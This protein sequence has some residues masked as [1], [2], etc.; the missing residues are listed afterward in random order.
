MNEALEVAQLLLASGHLVGAEV[1][2]QLSS[3]HI[4]AQP[5]TAHLLQEVLNLDELELLERVLRP[6]AGLLGVLLGGLLRRELFE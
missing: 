1:V 5:Q 2:V 6:G 4:V 3:K